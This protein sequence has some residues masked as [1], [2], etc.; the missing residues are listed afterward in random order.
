M[1]IWAYRPGAAAIFLPRG[2]V[3]G[4]INDDFPSAYL[5]EIK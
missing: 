1:Q 2:K 4:V 3:E 5:R